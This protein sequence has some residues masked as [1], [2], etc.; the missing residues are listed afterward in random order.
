MVQSKKQGKYMTLFNVLHLHVR[1]Q[2]FSPS[3]GGGGLAGPG[4]PD[5]K[6]LGQRFLLFLLCF[7]PH[8]QL[9]QQFYRGDRSQGP[10]VYLLENN[11]FS[12]FQRASNILRGWGGVQLFSRGGGGG[13]RPN[14]SKIGGPSGVKILKHIHFRIMTTQFCLFTTYKCS[15]DILQPSSAFLKPRNDMIGI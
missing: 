13:G 15:S 4:P 12:R 10:M 11:N 1:I 7:S 6:K 5:S 2:E 3:G 9:I 8:L 14:A